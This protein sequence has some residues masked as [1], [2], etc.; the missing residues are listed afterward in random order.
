MHIEASMH[1]TIVPVNQLSQRTMPASVMLIKIKLLLHLTIRLRMIH[2]TK[3][4]P[5]TFFL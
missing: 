1:P 3:K 2:S 4:L 5:D